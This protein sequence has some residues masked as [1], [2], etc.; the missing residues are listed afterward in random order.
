MEK[1]TSPPLVVMDLVAAGLEVEVE[2]AVVSDDAGP[3]PGS[4]FRERTGEDGA[5]NELEREMEIG[6]AIEAGTG[7][8][9]GF[10]A[11]A[12][13]G[14]EEKG[15]AEEGTGRDVEVRM[16]GGGAAV[17]EDVYAEK[18]KLEPE[19]RSTRFLG[20]DFPAKNSL[21]ASEGSEEGAGGKMSDWN[22]SALKGLLS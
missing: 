18:A 21:A 16:D 7:E 13:T 5:L 11:L 22:E 12:G 1:L 8:R 6:E 14:E 20:A 3:G 4:D 17:V 15:I 19:E 2:V 9:P 10:K